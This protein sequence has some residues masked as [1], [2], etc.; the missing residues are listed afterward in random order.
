MADV[1]EQAALLALLER[2]SQRWHL[3]AALVERSGSALAVVRD[4]AQAVDAEDAKLATTLAAGVSEADVKRYATAITQWTQGA[5]R[6]VTVLDEGYPL[7]LQEVFNRP[8][9]LFLRGDLQPQDSRAVAVVGTRQAS[10][11]GRAQARALA[12]GL[13]AQG[14]TVLSGLAR[15]IDTA[16]HEGVLAAGGRTVAVL[17]AGIRQPIYP[18]EN[19]ELARRVL[20]QGA[21][22]SQ[23]WPDAPP[24]Q[25]TFPLRNIT[26]SGLALGTV[27]VE[28][29]GQSGASLQARR[30]L[31]HGKRLFLVRS[32]VLREDWARR[33]AEH[34]G[35]LVVDSA[36]DVIDVLDE[37]VD[38]PAQLTIC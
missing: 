2:V 21:L 14:V 28:A 4:A 17:G 20:D 36:V 9:F 15:G 5:V 37:L 34:P 38:P 16:A 27:V 13:A 24:T 19:R 3:V 32:L 35:V 30:C 22:V 8:P 12:S 23:F 1:R 7:N 31:E 18:A 11:E 33:Y 10:E 25:A 6:L 26:M 29:H